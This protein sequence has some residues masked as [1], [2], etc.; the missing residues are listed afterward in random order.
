LKFGGKRALITNPEKISR[1]LQGETGDLDLPTKSFI[2]CVLAG[3]D[4]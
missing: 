4:F 1:A 3:G 2:I